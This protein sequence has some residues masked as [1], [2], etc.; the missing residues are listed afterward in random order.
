VPNYELA[1]V[2]AAKI[3]KYLLSD[4]HR[5]GQ[6]KAAFFK[7]H[8][9]REEAPEELAHALRL[10]LAVHEFVTVEESEFGARY[11]VDGIMHTP[12]GRGVQIWFIEQ[13]ERWPRLVTAYPLRKGK[14]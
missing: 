9:F 4:T 6:H 7:R 11:A 10:H 13:G 8:G 5:S 1:I 3:T 2:P 12:S 14:R